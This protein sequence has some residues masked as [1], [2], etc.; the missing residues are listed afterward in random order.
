MVYFYYNRICIV[1]PDQRHRSVCRSDDAV[2]W[3]RAERDIGVFI[4][5][6]LLQDT[7]RCTWILGWDRGIFGRSLL[8]A[9]R[10]RFLH[11]F[12]SQRLSVPKQF[13]FF[14]ERSILCAQITFF[15]FKQ[16]HCLL[17]RRQLL[18][19]RSL[20]LVMRPRAE[21][22]PHEGDT[23]ER[24][25]DDDQAQRCN[26]EIELSGIISYIRSKNK[27]K[28][29]LSFMFL[30]FHKNLHSAY[31]LQTCRPHRHLLSDL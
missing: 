27:R 5:I 17:T 11:Q 18:P 7:T 22:C 23:Y 10:S 9:L 29:F 1:R 19:K 13:I 28:R 15:F 8:T 26:R 31:T 3:L 21:D 12:S 2:L 4:C 14:L 24:H 16:L 25:Q 20:A 30:L 6:V